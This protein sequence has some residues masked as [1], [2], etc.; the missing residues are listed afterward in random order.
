M[1]VTDREKYMHPTQ[2]QLRATFS[3]DSA[4]GV[5][6]R[7]VDGERCGHN[8]NR[9]AAK[10]GDV[11][12]YVGAG[13]YVLIRAGA[14]S[15]RAHRLAWLYVY[16]EWPG[17]FIDHIDGNVK[18][19]AI[20]NLRKAT[21]SQNQQ[22]KTDESSRSNT[23]YLGVSFH[24]SSGKFRAQIKIGAERKWLGNFPSAD[25]ASAAY[26]QAKRAGHEFAPAHKT[27]LAESVG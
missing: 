9:P 25:L 21:N 22:N 18:N 20:S 8:L 13:G 15:Y 1:G 4:T 24:K 5:F 17:E 19:N 7:L 23:G 3:Y 11:V 27:R 2:E 16:G 10:R 12:G 6:T 26:W 14:R